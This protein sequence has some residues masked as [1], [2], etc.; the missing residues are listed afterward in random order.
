[1][2]S[3]NAVPKSTRKRLTF[4][5]WGVA[6]YI[7]GLGS[8]A[9]AQ[10]CAPASP[11]SLWGASV[12]P[13]GSIDDENIGVELG[14]QFRSDASG[15]ITGLRFYKASGSVNSH[16]VKLWSSTG[17][18]MGT[19][20]PS[21]ETASGWQQ[22]NFASPV[23][24]A[25]NTT[26]VASYFVSDGR[27]F[28]TS[29]YFSTSGVDNGPL[30]AP[31]TGSVTNGNGVY[32][33][34]TSSFPN[35]TWNGANYWI[36]VAFSTTPPTDTT[37]PT[38]ASVTPASGTTGV[39]TN[40]TVGVTFSENMTAGTIS[41]STI[42]LRNSANALITS[43]VSYNATTRVA[44]LT[45]SSVLGNSS[46]Y[47]VRVLGGVTDPRVKDL[48]GNALATTFT[49][50]FTT[51]A[52]V[53]CPCSLWGAS[54]VPT[55]SIDDENIG[56]ELGVQFRSDASGYITGLRFYK[57]SGSVNSHSVKLWSSTGTLMGTATPSSETASGWQQVNFASPVA[58]AANT[59]YVASYFVSD[60]RYFATSNYFS[61]SGV[62]NG[63]LHA[64]ATGSVTNGNGVY[65]P[66]TSS[67]PNQT[68]NGANYW[69]DVA[70]STT[71]P[72]DTTAPTVASVTPASGTTGV[73]TNTTVGVTFSEN[74]TAG[75][76]STSTI[77]LRNSANALITSTVSYNATTRVATLTPSSV[78]GNS[79]TYTVRVLGGVT[80]PRV[81][82][83]AGNALA[84]TFTSTF[85]T[86]AP[87]TCPCSLWGASVVPTG[88]IDDENIG[89]EL[90]VQFRSDASGYITGL[91]FYKASGSVNSHSV[92]LWSSTGTLMGTA[93]PSSETASGWQQ[94]NFASPVAIAAN[95]TYV[96]SY[97]VSDGRY[98][99]TSNY[100]STSGVDNGPL[101]APATGSV[102]NGNGVYSP[103]T[104]SFPNQTW[105]GANYWID[106]AFSTTPPTDTTAP[107]VASVTPAAASIG[108]DIGANVTATFS[109]N[110][111][112]S[113]LTSSTFE[114]RNVST[115][116]LV[117]VAITYDSASRIATLNPT[118][119]LANSTTYRATIKGGTSGVKDS[120]GNA[121]SADYIWTFS[122]EA[123]TTTA[124]DQ[125]PGGPVL[126][127][128][129]TTNLFSKYY[130][131]ILRA[132]GI[133]SFSVADISTVSSSTLSGYD[134]VILGN[135]PL[136]AAQV[137]I[138][139]NW[140]TAGG[141][142]I[143]MRP[144][145]Q[146]AGLLGLTDATST[147]S[148]AYMLVNTAMAPGAGI[149]GQTMQFHGSADRYLINGATSVAT[150]YSNA[151]TGTS[152]PA[153]SLRSVGSSGG[154]A[155][156]F[157]YD[158]ARSIVYTRQGN[159]AWAGQERDGFAPRRSDDLFF[160][161]ASGDV[162]PDWVDFNK[163]AVP[164]AD[165]QQ[166]LLAN[167]II[168]MN[169][170]RKPLPRFWYLP[171]GLKAVVLMTGDDH[172]NGG[173]VGRWNSYLA[174]SP[175]GCVLE[176][177]DC[178][179]GTSYIYPNTPIS[180]AQATAYQAQG[181]ELARHVL[182]DCH[183]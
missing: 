120:A 125:G 102:T 174:I 90:G 150:L 59:T 47:T 33:P 92:K 7:L 54:V 146:L 41:T 159:P 64:P 68:W 20:T 157:T 10:T 170:D 95:T 165:E 160:G 93:T 49:S 118:G 70:F 69:I 168:H 134:V 96:A 123:G 40:T 179:R 177:W 34:N 180:N 126:V 116:V 86:G 81:K 4:F 25:A 176:D 141:N 17:T 183:D 103:N 22:V 19:A 139:S 38:V 48:A 178:V 115:N 78:L 2:N 32:S 154:Q 175:A 148:N 113:T 65:S 74:M 158:L 23:A 52:P 5:A 164:Q 91:R 119:N 13:T 104:S 67:F 110:I 167:M 129:S 24:I 39:L 83:L 127:V 182:T 152:S 88:S 76:I 137:T 97:F 66:N 100:F 82:D 16:S 11:C 101:H 166:R 63:P 89:V 46:T 114:L 181:F 136:T 80:D 35:Q 111:N 15:Y 106:V 31:A 84:T 117:L 8:P 27:Y 130:A 138:F 29:N 169:R 58:I 140:V 149:V 131:E 75:T 45:P 71:P 60:G 9:E 57:A 87:V 145:K 122:T 155:A 55:G 124:I 173:T 72:T 147:L 121:L 18:L 51:G 109:E 43:T 50:T 26:Y 53:T 105:N 143:A 6:L 44:T 56:V 112:S 42:E 28:A 142:L 77:E 94:V 30:H 171:D 161:A 107:T 128:S 172:A 62:D 61:T 133:N 21:S 135:I 99:A 12:V 79:S 14:V 132:E 1:M 151:T 156:A 163:I 73:L 3:S 37:A 36:D 85:T 108:I 144:D 153:V 98:F 162:Q